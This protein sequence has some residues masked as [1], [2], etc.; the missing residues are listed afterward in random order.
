ML[1][2]KSVLNNFAVCLIGASAL[3]YSTGE[4]FAR[5]NS[6][7]SNNA[8]S[9]PCIESRSVIDVRNVQLL[10]VDLQESLVDRSKTSSPDDIKRAAGVLANIGSILKLPMLFSVVPEGSSGPELIP[11]LKQY[12]SAENTILRHPAGALQD[13]VTSNK[14]KGAK[15]K[16]LVLAGYAAEVAVLHS[17]LDAI[18]QGYTVYYVV[19]AIG[20]PSSR[21]EDATFAELN[22]AGA[23]PTSVLALT[24][25]LAPDFFHEPGTSVINSLKPLL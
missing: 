24:T 9:A 16:I 22:R 7:C 20:S 25:R 3:V 19:D 5:E 2:T 12:A 17:A 21:T 23:I 11:S 14:L 13:K 8:A 18:A 4:A 1:S 15:R 10:F 6:G